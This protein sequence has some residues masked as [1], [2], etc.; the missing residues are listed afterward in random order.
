MC[1]CWYISRK[2]IEIDYLRNR[3]QGYNDKKIE[4]IKKIMEKSDL[5]V[6]TG[7]QHR[8]VLLNS[9]I[10]AERAIYILSGWATIY[11]IDVSFKKILRDALM[12]GVN[13]YLGFGWISSNQKYEPKPHETEAR[14]I[15]NRA[16]TWAENVPNTGKLFVAE[17]PNHSK[18]LICDDKFAVCGSCNWL[19]NNSFNNEER[20]WKILDND[21]IHSEAN[22]ISANITAEWAKSKVVAIQ[23]LEAQIDLEI[24]SRQKAEA[25]A[26]AEAEARKKTEARLNELERAMVKEKQ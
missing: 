4:R 3:L 10:T 6:I 9:L 12:R 19:S 18:I 2:R 17:Y 21:F 23:K 8:E 1:A 24:K 25:R 11:V 15:L 7:D 22:E 20:S 13:I 16:A 26:K 5:E 14:E